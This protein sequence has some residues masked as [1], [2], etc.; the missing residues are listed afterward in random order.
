MPEQIPG[1]IQARKFLTVDENGTDR[2][3]MESQGIGYFDENGIPHVRMFADGIS[4]QDE[5]FTARSA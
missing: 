4:C 3:F 2:A 5:N 1:A